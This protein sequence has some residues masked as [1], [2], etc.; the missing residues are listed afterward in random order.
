MAETFR[1]A[2]RGSEAFNQRLDQALQAASATLAQA[3]GGALAAGG[4]QTT[5]GALAGLILSGGYG[6][7]EGSVVRGPDGTEQAWNDVDLTPV[8]RPGR[9]AD[10]VRIVAGIM[11]GQDM[12][13]VA[14]SGR[15]QAIF[16]STMGADLDFGRVLE[17]ADIRRLPPVLLWI[18]TGRGH[19]IIGGDP[20]LFSRN[21]SFDPAMAPDPV[22]ASKL[23]LNR[24]AGLLMA[25]VKA[26]GQTA[27]AHDCSDPDFVRRNAAK[28]GLALG[29]ALLI[30]LGQYETFADRKMEA[31]RQVRQTMADQPTKAAWEP[32]QQQSGLPPLAAMLA[33]LV[34][35]LD[36]AAI[37][38]VYK[39]ALDFKAD[40]DAFRADPGA[41]ELATLARL[42]IAVFLAVESLRSGQVWDGVAAWISRR[43]VIEPTEH[44]GVRK[45]GRNL[46]HNARQGRLGLRY[47]REGL[48]RE[49]P[50]LLVGISR[51]QV[52]PPEQVD[53]FI[54]LWS[55][56]N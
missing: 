25:A 51:G 22:E 46:V 26:A 54:A 3:A 32:T 42:W 55:R 36:L 21:L 39:R 20:N 4:A 30:A 34:T 44:R 13:G 7:G 43:S 5:G 49:L 10:L 31:F 14:G 6:R 45:L 19:R 9:K 27:S 28:C 2:A 11:A 50:G 41:V 15:L 53:S 52:P 12:A 48:F 38:E 40:P 56:Y 29:D 35:G 17:E 47:P 23:L 33:D 24:G 1:Y 37:E 8:A 16:K 18:E